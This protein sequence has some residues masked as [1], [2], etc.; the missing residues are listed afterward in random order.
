MKIRGALVDML[1]DLD[2]ELYLS[3]VV[4]ENGEKVLYVEVL[5][6]YTLC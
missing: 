4:Y 5:K 1:C 6:P 3:Y 2:S